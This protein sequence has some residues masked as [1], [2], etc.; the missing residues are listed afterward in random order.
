[1]SRARRDTNHP[2]FEEGFDFRAT[3]K[4]KKRPDGLW[5]RV[6]IPRAAEIV[7]SFDIAVTLRQLHYRLFAE[8]VGWY[9]NT[10]YEYSQLS[11]R[12]AELRRLGLFPPLLDTTRGVLTNYT[13]TS[14]GDALRDVADN[15][16]RDRSEGQEV[17]P[18][19]LG[20]KATLQGLLRNW[21]GEEFGIAVCA[22][23]G[24]QSESLEREIREFLDPD[25][26]YRALYVGDFDSTGEDIER[27]AERYLGDCFVDWT[28][29][30]ITP[31][32]VKRYRLPE[33]LDA[34]RR[35]KDSRKDGFEAKHG[36]VVQVEVEA[37][38]PD[39]LRSLIQAEIDKS[40]DDAAYQA[41]LDREEREREQAR[42]LASK[43]DTSTKRRRS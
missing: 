12:T 2:A 13:Y 4:P 33:N 21:F 39:T 19:L 20:E 1:M 36:K 38:D 18:V 43:L 22:L 3:P 7:A 11:R 27:N 40:W 14:L 23:R 42:R 29:V 17:A 34:A 28:R 35:K 10:L 6:I 8:Q 24:Y 16:L 32:Q 9:D 26:R 30:A 15:Y 5:E 41:A 25:R 31:A 37:L